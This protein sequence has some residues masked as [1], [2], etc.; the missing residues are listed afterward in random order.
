M[1][2]VRFWVPDSAIQLAAHPPRPGTDEIGA[3]GSEA[4]A[5]ELIQTDYNAALQGLPAY[6]IFD[7]MRFSDS[8]IGTGLWVIK[9]PLMRAT[10]TVEPPTDTPKDREIAEFVEADLMGMTIPWQEYLWQV[11][12]MLDYGSFPFEIVW[13]IRDDHRA[14][15]RK[16]APRHPRTVTKWLIDDHGGF[17]GVEQQTLRSSGF[18][19]VII[20]PEKLIVYVNQKEGSNFR[21]VSLLRRVYK[22]WMITERLENAVARPPLNEERAWRF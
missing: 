5:G 17:N 1:A 4:T 22:H 13:E 10:W 16:L 2:E 20:P 9:L 12:L 14:H 3:T 7:R 19:T 6:D 15:L 18:H 8:S 11:F 21:G